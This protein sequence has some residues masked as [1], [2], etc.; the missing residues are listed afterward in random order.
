[1]DKTKSKQYK[2][3][4][5]IIFLL[6]NM[7]SSFLLTSDFLLV[8]LSPYPRTFFMIVNSLFGDFGFLLTFLSLSI[9]IFKRDYY[10]AKFLM[11]VSIIF[12]IL[13]FGLSVYSQH[14]NMFFSF[15]NLSAFGYG[16]TGDTVSFIVDSLLLLLT[17][18]KFVFLFSAVIIILVF[19]F[20][21]KKNRKDL[22]FKNSSLVSGTNRLTIGFGALIVGILIMA[23]SLSAYRFEIMDTWYE[24]N[25]SPIY[26][27]Q[28]VGL[29]NY[30]IYDAYS[31]F[32]DS[33]SLKNEDKYIYV[34]NKLEEYKKPNRISPINDEPYQ[35]S[36]YQGAFAGKNLL[37]IQMESMNNFVIGLQV[38][39]N[40]E[41]VE[42]TPNLNKMLEKSIYFNNY[43]T[44]VGIGNTSDSE[45][46][47]LTG[48]YPIGNDYVIYNHDK[49]VYPSL[50]RLF[51]ENGYYTY[52]AHANIGRFYERDRVHTSLYGFDKHY[53]AED[54]DISEEKLVHTW[55]SDYDFLLEN[56]DVLN[57]KSK[58]GPVFSFAI[59]ISSHL[60]Y[61]KPNEAVNGG[62]WFY[63]KENLFPANFKVVE[64]AAVNQQIVGYLEHINYTD[65]AIGEAVKRLEELGIADDTIVVLY[66]D[67]GCDIPA[68]ELFYQ[69]PELVRND[70]NPVIEYIDDEYLR[71]MF[72]RRFLSNIPFIIYDHSYQE[73]AT[74]NAI[75]PQKI[76]LV[77]GTSS[78]ANTL[79]NLFGLNAEYFFGIDALSNSKTYS[80]NPRNLDIFADGVIISGQSR[81]YLIVDEEYSDFYT[82]DLINQI[83]NDLL[84][85]KDFNDKV[86]KYEIFPKLIVDK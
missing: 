20:L 17:S 79:A 32:S 72:N 7:I 51:S 9:L 65:Y 77:R 15:Y 8:N 63:G 46:T 69:S 55:L 29:F 1:M 73:K 33:N 38:E 34:K 53:S 70:I 48:L 60:P 56:V 68:F 35:I 14:Y 78:T 26:G 31:F 10:R 61:R 85:Y 50:A 80:Y 19:V 2:L 75:T 74:S 25:S 22:E 76:E 67:H 6:T 21:F 59:T 86:L 27:I 83:V 5:V 81:K 64:N 52:S 66:G 30:Y 4:F 43:F 39:V 49:V 16:E 57:D 71:A 58:Q 54:F 40:G 44:S 23:N 42:I 45:F 62:A 37:L 36:P 47:S 11:I 12:G 3:I 18:A 13:Y 28:N 82:K 84:D 41:M 24:D